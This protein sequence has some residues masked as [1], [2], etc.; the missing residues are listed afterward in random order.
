M[1]DP[2]HLL[3]CAQV[4]FDNLVAVNPGIARHPMYVIARNQLDE[5]VTDLTGIKETK[6]ETA[7]R[8]LTNAM[9]EKWST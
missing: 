5:A 7:K 1:T 9:H 4:N 2:I 6:L 8:V 3:Q